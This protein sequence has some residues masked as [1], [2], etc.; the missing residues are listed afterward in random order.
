VLQDFIVGMRSLASGAKAMLRADRT[1]ALV[2]T[3]AHGRYAESTLQ[4]RRF[5]FCNTGFTPPSS[6]GSLA[7][8][9]GLYN[10]INSGV[11]AIIDDIYFTWGGAPSAAANIFLV[12]NTAVTTTPTPLTA[13]TA[14]Q[15]ML[16]RPGLGFAPSVGPIGLSTGCFIVPFTACTLPSAPFALRIISVI[17]A[18][19]ATAMPPTLDEVAGRIVLAPGSIISIAASTTTPA[20]AA[21]F[22]WEEALA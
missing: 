19:G 1:S 7:A 5:V 8:T 22:T 21:S 3:D 10:P 18:S 17:L 2:T 20:V 12:A 4:G 13:A 11:N 15:A 6:L 9:C 14:R 16:N